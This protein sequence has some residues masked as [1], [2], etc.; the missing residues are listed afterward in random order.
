MGAYTAYWFTEGLPLVFLLIG[1]PIFIANFFKSFIPAAV[2][3]QPWMEDFL[4]LLPVT[5]SYYALIGL[6]QAY[7][8]QEKSWLRKFNVFIS[9]LFF[10]GLHVLAWNQLSAYYVAYR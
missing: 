2:P 3:V 9:F 7:L 6:H 8:K 10:V 5:I 1:P 4:L